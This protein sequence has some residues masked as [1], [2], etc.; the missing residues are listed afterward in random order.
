MSTIN[1]EGI[2]YTRVSSNKQVSDGNGLDSQ[3]SACL[4]YASEKNINII[5]TI[6]DPGYSGKSSERP[7][8]EELWEFLE[9]KTSDVYVIADTIDR[10]SRDAKNYHYFKDDLAEKG[11]IL[12]CLNHD[13]ANTEPANIF[14]EH[15]KGYVSVG[16]I[17]ILIAVSSA[18]RDEA[19]KIC[20]Y[21]L[22]EIKHKSPIWK[23]E[24]YIEGN[25]QW[26][27]GHSLRPKEEI[28]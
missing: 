17:S 23:K 8:V 26:L 14:L 27:P 13:F 24:H 3:Y 12:R 5:K 10:F 18:H 15:A 28:K 9:S 16:E 7:G 21:I 11:G 22:E 19:F 20:R 6:I 25:E 4:R 1:K 2:I